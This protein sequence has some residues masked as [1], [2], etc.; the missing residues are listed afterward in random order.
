M[1]EALTVSPAAFAAL[2]QVLAIDLVLAGD[3]A[4]VVGALAAGLPP[5][6]RKRVILIGIMA[7]LVLR[8]VFALMVSQLLGII[9]LVLAGGLLLLWVAWKMYRELHHG[10]VNAGSPEVAGDGHSGLAPAKSF[11]AA[12][13]SVALAD[14]SMSLDNVLAV[15]GAAREHP[16]VMVFGLVLSVILMGV[17][18][19]IIA[20]YI[21]RFR[22]IPWAGLAVIVWVACKMIWEGWLDVHPHVQLWLG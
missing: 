13:W 10:A 21:E 8:V 20:K 12:A 4:I 1:I 9:G 6:Q 5:E 17:A 18:A 22:W 16:G 14:V 7:A 11:A 19:N 15:A 3:N 2:V